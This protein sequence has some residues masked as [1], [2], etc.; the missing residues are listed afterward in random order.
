MVADFRVLGHKRR[1]AGIKEIQIGEMLGKNAI[2]RLQKTKA[3]GKDDKR[4]MGDKD[5]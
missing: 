1:R 5:W 4:A 2:G 3:L